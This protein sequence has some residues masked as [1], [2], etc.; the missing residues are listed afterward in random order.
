MS[1][2]DQLSAVRANMLSLEQELREE[3]SLVPG[4]AQASARNLVHYM[5]LRRHDLRPLQQELAAAGL[6]SLGR[7]EAHTLDTVNRV[8]H[9]LRLLEPPTAQQ[10]SAPEPP[11]PVDGASGD[12][13]LE[14][15]TVALLGASRPGRATR[16]MVTAPPEAATNPGLVRELADAGMDLLRIN[17]AHDLPEAWGQMARN[18]REALH[19]GGA[20]GRILFDLAG[21]KLRTGPVLPGP[22]I[23]HWHVPRDERGE[24]SSQARVFLGQGS[25]PPEADAALPLDETLL[26][27]LEED[28]ALTF[29][30]VPGRRRLIRVVK[31]TAGGFWATCD[32]SAWVEDGTRLSLHRGGRI[33]GSGHATPIAPTQGTL[34]LRRGDTLLLTQPGEPGRAALRTPDGHVLEPARIPCTLDAVF[35]DARAG[36]RIF[37]DDG[38]IGGIIRHVHP[39][40]LTV[41]LQ[42]FLKEPARLGADKGINLPDSRLT[43]PALTDEDL[44]HLDI[45]AEH[46]DLVGLSFVREP[47]DVL[48]LHQELERR[49]M[50]RIGTVLKIET[51]AAF[52]N[53]PRLLLTALRRPPV[54]VMV[55]RGD[56][57]VE[58]GFERLA[59][60]QEEILWLSESAHMPVIWATQ[61]LDRLT[62]KGVPSRAEVTDAA[63]GVRAECVMLNKGPFLPQ[64]VRFLDDVLRRM[65]A[66]QHKKRA[67][68]RELRWR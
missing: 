65:Q 64:A 4:Q 46:G 45:V 20:R 58:V 30:D 44:H 27:R 52:H 17:C 32:H 55:A 39:D 25:A 22:S 59:E 28:D 33:V 8:L 15:N 57:G 31:R 21:P 35:R 60:I 7:S 14:R 29:R 3:I 66:H 9:F 43:L 42:H 67:M 49:S 38:R 37:F 36:E 68:L 10:P 1:L 47:Q 54:A 23:L 51:R 19:T 26:N 48:L 63:M 61:V 40:V 50:K 2:I 6:S 18:A 56:L 53:L 13:L 5:A 16:I 12:A 62:R 24:P 34:W 11:P 41:E